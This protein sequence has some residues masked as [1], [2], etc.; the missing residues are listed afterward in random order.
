MDIFFYKTN[1][2]QNKLNKNLE[3]EKKLI[4]T[5]KNNTDLIQPTILL[6]NINISDNYNFCYI[7]KLKRYYFIQNK[8]IVN[9]NLII[10]D[11]YI[12]VLMT[13]KDNI[14]N[15]TYHIITQDTINNDFMNANINDK[16]INIKK[17]VYDLSNIESDN[18][19]LISRCDEK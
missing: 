8:K 16:K 9:N 13:Y 10:C 2:I 17:Y 3:N 12:D 15:G 7:P 11:L 14:L 1:D 5:I 6:D 19:I 4:C 18:I